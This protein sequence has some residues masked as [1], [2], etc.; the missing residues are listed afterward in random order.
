MLAYIYVAIVMKTLGTVLMLKKMCLVGSVM[1]A[2]GVALMTLIASIPCWM[3]RR[4]KTD[5]NDQESSV[6]KEPKNE[7]FWGYISSLF[8]FLL[9]FAVMQY[10]CK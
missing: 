2:M 4:G 9:T 8:A 6:Y 1:M 5:P 7:F 3:C 10:F